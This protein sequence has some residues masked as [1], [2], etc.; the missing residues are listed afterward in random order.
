M[1]RYSTLSVNY[2][3]SQT[4]RRIQQTEPAMHGLVFYLLSNPHSNM[5]GVYRLPKMYMAYD[6]GFSL[7]DIDKFLAR[8]IE[9]DFCS[10]DEAEETIWVH[11]MLAYQVAETLGSNDKRHKHVLQLINELPHRLNFLPAFFARYAENYQLTAHNCGYLS[12]EAPSKGLGRGFQGASKPHRS[13]EQEQE[14]E[15]EQKQD[16]YQEQGTRKRTI[17]R[18]GAREESFIVSSPPAMVD[19]IFRYWKEVMQEPEAKLDSARHDCIQNALSLGYDAAA[20]QQ[21]IDGCAITPYNL[22]QNPAGERY[23]GL[24]V[25]FRHADSIDRFRR[26]LFH[27]PTPAGASDKPSNLAAQNE[28]AG[29][30]WLAKSEQEDAI[31]GECQHVH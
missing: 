16:I 20:L 31:E 29:R 23:V 22:G 21:A 4:G 10:Y 18:V 28:A 30:A 17:T 15:Q 26:N 1:R 25:I 12:A 5:L 8:L 3:S 11:N 24:H 9:W 14:L 27:P 2:W 13:Q 7:E 19:K 6:T